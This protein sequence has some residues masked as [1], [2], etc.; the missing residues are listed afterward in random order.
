MFRYNDADSGGVIFP[1]ELSCSKLH[2]KCVD[3][4]RYVTQLCYPKMCNIA[5]HIYGMNLHRYVHILLAFLCSFVTQR[6]V[7]SLHINTCICV[8]KFHYFNNHTLQRRQFF[9]LNAKNTFLTREPIKLFYIDT[10]KV[11]LL[12]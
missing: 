4:C 2:R 1:W 11:W 6:C 8:D 9:Y 12:K 10:C 3:L 7:T 5:T